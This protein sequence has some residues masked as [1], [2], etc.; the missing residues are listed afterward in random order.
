MAP[1]EPSMIHVGPSSVPVDPPMTSII[2]HQT[3]RPSSSSQLQGSVIALSIALP[4]FLVPPSSASP[5]MSTAE[6]KSFEWFVR[7][8]PRGLVETLALELRISYQSVR[9]D[10]VIWPSLNRMELLI[11]LNSSPA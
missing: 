10:Y 5:A 8:A 7:L 4:R 2:P 1:A 9:T 11:S 3:S 6:Q